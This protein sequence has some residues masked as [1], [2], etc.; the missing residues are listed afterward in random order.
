MTYYRDI[1]NAEQHRYDEIKHDPYY[2]NYTGSSGSTRG[3]LLAFGVIALIS[4]GLL[5]FSGGSDQILGEL[6][7]ERASQPHPTT[8][9][10]AE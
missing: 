4:A 2:D 3:I 1:P 5:M 6:G 8:T 10:L 9:T 7:A